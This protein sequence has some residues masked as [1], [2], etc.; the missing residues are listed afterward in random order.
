MKVRIAG[1]AKEVRSARSLTE[2]QRLGCF[3][4]WGV[5][6]TKKTIWVRG[7]FKRSI[8]DRGPK[9]NANQ[10]IFVTWMHNPLDPIGRAAELFEDE[11]G[12][13]VVAE[14][15]DPTAVPNAKRAMSQIDSGTINGW[16]FGFDYIYTRE[17][18]EYQEATDSVLVKDV[19]LMETT[20]IHVPSIKE[21]FSVRGETDYE[22]RKLLFDDEI[23]DFMKALPKQKQLELR[24]L[25]SEHEALV[26]FRPEDLQP[27]VDQPQD[28]E[29][30]VGSLRLNINKL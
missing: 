29:I 17:A 26:Q 30:R 6:D 4:V 25:I 27:I 11:F 2:N 15:D 3:C 28:G 14:F 12:A 23:S 20:P 22:S 24:H 1:H 19:V 16:S 5:R 10:K 8:A 18:L 9:S 13:W 21:T 7:V